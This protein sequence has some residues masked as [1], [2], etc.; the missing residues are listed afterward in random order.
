MTATLPAPPTQADKVPPRPKS[1]RAIRPTREIRPGEAAE[2]LMIVSSACAVIALIC[3]WVLLQ[4]LLLGGLAQQRSQHLLYDEYRA[5]LAQAT[6]PTGAL[7]YQGK[8]VEPGAP[9]ALLTIPRLGLQQVVVSGTAASD[10]LAGPGH[11]RTTPLPGQA[12]VSVVMGRGSTYGAPFGALDTLHKGD[13]ITIRNGQGQ[14][15]YTVED[16]RRAGDPIPPVPTGATAGRL[17]LVT[18][19]GSGFLSALRPQSAVYLDAV[20]AKATPAGPVVPSVPASEYVM[21]RDTSGLPMIVLL[22]ALA[23]GLVVA[24]SLARRRFR[25]ALVWL[26]AAPV[27][28]AL[29]WAVTDQVLGL[30]PNLM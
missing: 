10:L 15:F 13:Q 17:T 4:M 23:A 24:I 6:A 2:T 14:V 28:V 1:T 5:E 29:A 11:L 22:L 7:D 26:L 27:A 21:S 20:T 8:P 25:A 9:V 19:Q 3:C 12:G 18:A 16:I 30:L